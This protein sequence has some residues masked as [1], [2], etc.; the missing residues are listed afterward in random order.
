[1]PPIPAVPKG[2]T[3][4]EY[5][6][7]LFGGPTRP[8]EKVVSVQTTSTQLLENNPRRLAWLIINRSTSQGAIGFAPSTAFATGALLGA[9]GGSASM[10][11]FE[12][13]EAVVQPV[14]GVQDAAAG[15]YYVQEIIRV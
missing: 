10:A 13:G 14:W 7:H 4:A 1:M 9:S 2:S 12:D 5:S 15:N 3:A 11:V 6:E 8:L